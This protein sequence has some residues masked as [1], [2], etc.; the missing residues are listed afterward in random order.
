MQ[1]TILRLSSMT[2]P[3]KF[4]SLTSWPSPHTPYFLSS[5]LLSDM[6]SG[7]PSSTEKPYR[8]MERGSLLCGCSCGRRSLV[9]PGPANLALST[10]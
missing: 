10:R 7:A 5:G 8:P 2:R 6:T 9:S 4:G 3:T 1:A